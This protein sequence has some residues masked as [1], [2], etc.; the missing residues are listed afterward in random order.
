MGLAATQPEE[1]LRI[2]ERRVTTSS[3]STSENGGDATAASV[4]FVCVCVCDAPHREAVTSVTVRG[5]AAGGGGVANNAMA[6]TV[7][8][9]G[10]VKT[11]VP[12]HAARGGE[13][14][15]WKCRSAATHSGIPPP[16]LHAASFSHDGSLLATA[17]TDVAIWDPDAC[18]RLHTLAPPRWSGH[19]AA[20]QPPPMTGVAFVAGQPLLVGVSPAGMVVWNLMTLTAWRTV[21]VPCA[22]VV[23]HPTL[24]AF[25][26]TVV[27]RSAA[28]AAVRSAAAAASTAGAAGG[29]AT[30]S[31]SHSRAAAA[32]VDA[33]GCF[34]VQFEGADASPVKCWGTPGGAPQAVL[35]P[36]TGS[37]GVVVVT[38]DRRLVATAGTQSNDTVGDDDDDDAGEDVHGKGGVAAAAAAGSRLGTTT[39]GGA[40]K[41][42][43]QLARADGTLRADGVGIAS[44]VGANAKAGGG[45]PWGDLFDAPSHSLPPLTTLAPHFLDALLDHQSIPPAGSGGGR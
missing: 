31:D 17:G 42:F 16:P 3:S 36:P 20:T 32:G 21:S 18:V 39:T 41:S 40:L 1:T 19:A 25:A 33:A 24:S 28:V 8:L 45:V 38:H 15:G 7:S 29:D 34:V 14:A 6:A 35:Y 5:T 2:W 4:G 11:W 12:S 43:T 37:G 13:R 10:D 26:V 22:S 44:A 27:P 23:A 9:D 30:G